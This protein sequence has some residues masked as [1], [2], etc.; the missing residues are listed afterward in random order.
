MT[1]SEV[2]NSSEAN[3]TSWSGINVPGRSTSAPRLSASS[4]ITGQKEEFNRDKVSSEVKYADGKSTGSRIDVSVRKIPFS[5]GQ[6]MIQ[7]DITVN[8]QNISET[9][10]TKRSE[11]E[12]GIVKW[13]TLEENRRRL[14]TAYTAWEIGKS[15]SVD[16]I[17]SSIRTEFSSSQTDE[18]VSQV[19]EVPSEGRWG[20][21]DVPRRCLGYSSRWKSQDELAQKAGT[22]PCLHSFSILP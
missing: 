4:D 18:R 8:E 2:T 1:E 12:D 15:Q 14:A 11:E 20:G 13:S 22:K 17:S 16:R 7:N 21:I 5:H 9:V 6:H 10:G 3:E 19:E